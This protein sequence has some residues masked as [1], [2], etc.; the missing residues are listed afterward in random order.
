MSSATA[1]RFITFEGGEGVGKSTQMR[2]L[3]AALTAEGHDVTVTRE[4]GGTPGAEA[5]RHVVLGGA[6]KR[7]GVEIEAALFAAA[8]RDNVEQLIRPAL[9]S[10]HVVLCDRYMDS[11]RVY[12]GAVGGVE[13]WLMDV[14][15]NAVTE[16][17]RPDLTFVFDLPAERALARMRARQGTGDDDRY[18]SEGLDAHRRRRDAFL[19]IARAEPNRCVVIDADRDSDAIAHDVLAAA[20]RVLPEPAAV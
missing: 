3:T 11:S 19:A 10:G 16:G 7:F 2:L 13:T 9:A 20:R 1:G 15:E 17:A 4:P 6:A 14:F 5:V 18:E 12:Q 8:R